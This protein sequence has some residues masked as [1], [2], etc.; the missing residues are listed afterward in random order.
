VREGGFRLDNVEDRVTK[1]P[2]MVHGT[3]DDLDTIVSIWKG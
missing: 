3:I 1:L 2:A